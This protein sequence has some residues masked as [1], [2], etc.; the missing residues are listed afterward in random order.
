MQPT[1]IVT[2]QLM[3]KEG[4]AEGKRVKKAKGEEEMRGIGS[5]SWGRVEG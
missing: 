4:W 3:I 2:H 1:T 5:V